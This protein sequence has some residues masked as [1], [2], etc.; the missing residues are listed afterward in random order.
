MLIK[1]YYALST[2]K[3]T[4]LDVGRQ[5]AIIKRVLGSGVS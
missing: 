3:P 4:V 1:S 5:C 2:A